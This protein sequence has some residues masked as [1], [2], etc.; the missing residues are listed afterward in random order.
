[1][2]GAAPRT[3][4]FVRAIA[5]ATTCLFV[6]CLALAMHHRADVAHVSDASGASTHGIETDCHD[7]TPVTHLHEVPHEHGGETCALGDVLHQVVRLPESIAITK[8]VTSAAGAAL[9]P[10]V[11]AFEIDVLSSAPK[12]SPPSHA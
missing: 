2:F 8:P 1:M 5:L 12:T 11:V 9:V 10:A 6:T 7:G 4:G 3:R